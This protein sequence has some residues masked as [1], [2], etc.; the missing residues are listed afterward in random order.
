MTIATDTIHLCEKGA[1]TLCDNKQLFTT[2]FEDQML[3]CK[4]N[5]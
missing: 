1:L 3:F 4:E 5:N 2:M